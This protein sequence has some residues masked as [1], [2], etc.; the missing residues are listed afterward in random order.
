MHQ[1]IEQT[2]TGDYILFASEFRQII[3]GMSP[4]SQDISLFQNFCFKNVLCRLDHWSF[5]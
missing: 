2:G 1:M 3:T 5:Y 4:L